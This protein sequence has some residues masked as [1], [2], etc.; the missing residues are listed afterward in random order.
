[1]PQISARD[2]KASERVFEVAL[3]DGA[4]VCVR[5]D[6]SGPRLI[7]SH[8]NGLAIEAYRPFWSLLLDRYQVVTFDFRHHGLSSPYRGPMRNWPTFIQDFEQILAGIA[9]ELGSAA[10]VGVFHSMSALT[11]LLH[12]ADHGA[13]WCGLLAFE[14]PCPPPPGH[15]EFE[16]FFDMHRKLADG[17]QRR[18][19]AF[20]AA[21]DLAASFARADSFRRLD[22]ETL[23]GLAVATL[24]WDR[25]QHHYALACAPEFE[26][27]TFRLRNLE[28]AWQRVATVT[29]PVCIVA[30]IPDRDENRCLSNVARSLAEDSGFEFR[31]VADATHFL[32]MERPRQCAAIVD[33]FATRVLSNRADHVLP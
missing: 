19:P 11:A 18:R 8:G 17:A 3:P 28:G 25:S 5:A 10:S 15:L 16:P 14:P 2:A 12:A 31:T 9:R 26:A 23:D 24:R 29:L 6:G 32:Q 21:E 4:T 1:M 13:D 22:P 20:A 30:G 33:G 27:E 7:M